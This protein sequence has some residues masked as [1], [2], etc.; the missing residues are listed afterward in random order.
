MRHV[1]SIVVEDQAGALARIVELFTSR[2]YNLES[3]CTGEA[4]KP[5][6]QR[7]TLITRGDDRKIEHIIRLLNNIVYVFEVSDLHPS[8]SIS[9]E[10]MLMKVKIDYEIRGQILQLIDAYGGTVIEMNPESISFQVTGSASK[11][12]GLTQIFREFEIIEM[13]RTGESAIHK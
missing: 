10:L 4:E 7:L 2:G 5:G 13:A 1:I 11:L 3:I 8:E 9:R 12:N 6:I